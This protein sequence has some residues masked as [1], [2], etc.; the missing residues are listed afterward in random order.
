MICALLRSKEK[1]I[2]RDGDGRVLGHLVAVEYGADRTSDLVPAAQRLLAAPDAD[3]NGASY[4]SVASN[5]ARRLHPRS[6]TSS[7]LR[8]P[9]ARQ[10]NLAR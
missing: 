3:L 4:F 10:N 5:R 8:R 9:V 6:S 1:S 7:G 2:V